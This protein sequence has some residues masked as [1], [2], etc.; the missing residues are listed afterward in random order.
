MRKEDIFIV[1]AHKKWKTIKQ[2]YVWWRKTKH[3]EIVYTELQAL[4]E[5]KHPP[6]QR[7]LSAVFTFKGLVFFFA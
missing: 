3:S 6:R 5:R 4:W 7:T 2:L 1:N